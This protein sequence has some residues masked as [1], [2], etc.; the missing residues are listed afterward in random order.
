MKQKALVCK[1]PIGIFAF[2]ENGEL[3]HYRLFST[4]PEKAAE[5]FENPAL[6]L[7]YEKEESEEG[8]HFLRQNLREY[9][10]SL[11]FV[12]M[13]ECSSYPLYKSTG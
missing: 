9:A 10:V 5:E 11:G 2:A 12:E 3:L 6:D 4:K 8:Y 1:S 13:K 7:P